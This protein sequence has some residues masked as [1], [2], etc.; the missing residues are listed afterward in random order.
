[1]PDHDSHCP[2]CGRTTPR[3]RTLAEQIEADAAAFDAL[4]EWKR[5]ELL[6]LIEW[7]TRNV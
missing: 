3:A 2:H 4:P 7:R 6:R 5:A 1:M